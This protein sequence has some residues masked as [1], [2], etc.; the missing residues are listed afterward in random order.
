[1]ILRNL[2][3]SAIALALTA[4]AQMPSGES[5]EYDVVIR[6]GRVLDGAGNPWI[7]ADIGI[8]NGRFAKIGLIHSRG[9]K[10]IDATGKYVAPGFIDMMDQSGD[11]LARNGLAENKVKMGVTSA[12]AGEGGFPS[13]SDKPAEQGQGEQIPPEG[14]GAYFAKL[15]SQ[16][17]SMNFGTYYGATQ[18]RVEVMGDG[19]GKPTAEQMERMKDHVARAM[20]AGAFGITTA[21]IYPPSSFQLTEELIELAKVA[22]KYKGI[23]ASH[24]RDEGKDLL[25]AINEVIEISEK[26]GLQAEVFHFKAAY[27]PGWGK[28]MPQAVKLID[29]ARARGVNIAADMYVYTAGGTGLDVTAPNWVFAEG[30]EKGI[31]KLKDPAVRAKAKKDVAGGSLP[32]WSNLVEACGWDHIV[33]ADPHAERYEQYKGKSIAEIG[34]A[35][36]QDPADVAWDIV[37]AAQPNRAMG[38]YFFIDERDIETA[39]KAPWVAIGSDAAAADHGK[40]DALGLRHPRSY[41]VFPR[42]IAEYVRKRGVLTLPDAIRKM[43]SWPAARMGLSDRGVIREGLWADVVVFDFDQIKDE[44]TWENPFVYPSGIEDV[45]VNGVVVVEN[46]EHTGAKPGHVLRGPG[47]VQH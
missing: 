16:G 36:H 43:T 24:I 12:I 29:D 13:A 37:I 4:C 35:L 33:L 23:Y 40:I 19:D 1:L 7:R 18:A 20:Q 27:A 22:S 17:I 2:L 25:K 30:Y 9:K 14:I 6:N 39:L 3:L 8:V 42:V 34:K 31:A 21:L 10:E 26:G 11:Q 45:L 32:G 15:E 46:G 28:I 44:S 41:G 5:S 38:L 47:Y